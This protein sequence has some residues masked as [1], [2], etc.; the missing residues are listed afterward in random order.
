MKLKR[1]L[2]FS[3]TNQTPLTTNSLDSYSS[4]SVLSVKH[5]YI[6]TTKSNITDP[7]SLLLGKA[8]LRDGISLTRISSLLPPPAPTG[9]N[10]TDLNHH[11]HQIL[12]EID[13]EIKSFTSARGGGAFEAILVMPK[14][15]DK[16][17]LIVF[18]HGGPHSGF[19]TDF[20]WIVASMCAS[21]FAVL[22]VNYTGSVGFG[23]DCITS[24]ELRCLERK[25]LD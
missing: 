14:E 20:S 4:Y 5:G 3:S 10:T 7:G 1:T 9:T 17:P 22:M 13:W 11:H 21:G 6:L 16:C 19:T 15:G 12:S 2:P 24:K 8:E 23:E 18:P 25:V